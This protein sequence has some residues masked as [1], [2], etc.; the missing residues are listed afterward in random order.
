MDGVL[1]SGSLGLLPGAVD[2]IDMLRAAGKR[3]IFVTNN[4]A[5]SRAAY[6]EKLTALGLQSSAEEIVPSSFAAAR[7]LARERPDVK[8]AFVIGEAGVAE[9]LMAAGIEVVRHTSDENAGAF[10]EAA[11]ATCEPDPRIGAVVVGADPSFSFGALA[12]AS[13]CLQRNE[14]CTFVATNDDA[15]DVVNGRKLPGNGAAKAEGS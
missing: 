3:C 5:R 9:E 2:A 13:L 11:F 1:W 15:Y 14:G 12:M 10:D 8:A 6:L 4:S 7:W